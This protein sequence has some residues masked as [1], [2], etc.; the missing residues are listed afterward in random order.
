MPL[1]VASKKDF[2]CAR[3]GLVEQ[4]EVVW[5]LTDAESRRPHAGML[6]LP[7]DCALPDVQR[8][9]ARCCSGCRARQRGALFQTRICFLPQD[10]ALARN[11]C[12]D[13]VF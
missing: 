5:A 8:H 12:F 2:V 7:L 1:A 3:K 4:R 13:M 10:D 6:H 11:R 9:D